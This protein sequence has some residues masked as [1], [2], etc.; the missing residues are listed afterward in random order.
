MKNIIVFADYGL[1]DAAAT[2]SLFN[3]SHLF[4]SITLI[5]IGGN[6]PVEVSYRN[7]YCILSHYPELWN[8]IKVVSTCHINQPNEYLVDIHGK[9]GMGDVLIKQDN[10]PMVNEIRFEDWLL[11]VTGEETV[12]SLGPMTLVRALF[13]K[14]PCE[15]LVIMGGLICE[16]PNFNGYEFNQAMDVDAFGYCLKFPHVAITLDTCR[17]KAL[18]M[19]RVQINGDDLH[20]VIL[21]ADQKLS[22]SRGEDGCYVWDDVA[23]CYVLYPER[24]EVKVENDPYGNT[25]SNATYISDKL[26]FEN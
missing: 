6:V 16:E 26:Y 10:N 21:R 14:K 13:E 22:I 5:P 25:I 15:K 12:L 8:K 3:R 18:D 1:D 9:D 7:C 20:S 23:A 24:F 2:I 19:R 17:V 11:S 4:D